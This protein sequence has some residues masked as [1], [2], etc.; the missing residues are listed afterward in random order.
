MDVSQVLGTSGVTVPNGAGIYITDMWQES[1]NSASG[2]FGGVQSSSAP[3]GYNNSLLLQANPAPSSVG[4]GDYAFIQ[5]PIEGY[6]WARLGWG[7]AGAFPVTVGF[8]VFAS[9]TGTACMALRNAATNRCYLAPFT[10]VSANTWEYKRIT[11][12][13]DVTGTW[14]KDNTVGAFLDFTFMAGSNYQ[15]TANAWQAGGFLAASGIS[16]FFQ[17]TLNAVFITGVTC[18]PGNEGPDANHAAFCRRFMQDDI[19]LCKR[20]LQRFDEG[21]TDVLIG[22]CYSATHAFIPWFHSPSMRIGPTW[23]SVGSFQLRS[24]TASGISVGAL[25]FNSTFPSFSEI[26]ATVASGL[27]AGNATALLL[28]AGAYLQA[29]ARF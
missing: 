12:P 18:M 27:V 7:T 26:D 21:S 1:A 5:H 13:G 23:G 9:Q 3:P 11:V 29:D 15:G 25:T 16:N 2:V 22:Q 24:A 4:V 20:Y 19:Q 6:R 28:L 17:V 10:V 14:N 8:W